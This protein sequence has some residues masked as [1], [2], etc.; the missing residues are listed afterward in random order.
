[1]V[2]EMTLPPWVPMFSI[3][4]AVVS[5]VGGVLSHA[6]IVAREFGVP[7]VVGTDVGTKVIRTGQTVTVDGNAGVIYLDG[8]EVA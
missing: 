4:G 2:C 5:D 3:A 6:A 8:R 1:M 7:A